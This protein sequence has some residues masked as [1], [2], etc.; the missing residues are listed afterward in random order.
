MIVVVCEGCLFLNTQSSRFH[1]SVETFHRSDIAFSLFI[2]G[3]DTPFM[4]FSNEEEPDGNVR[5][6]TN[7]VDTL[8]AVFD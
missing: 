5:V 1:K 8:R 2:S 6:T 3:K 7:V 4:D